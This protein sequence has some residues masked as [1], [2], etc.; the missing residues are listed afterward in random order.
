M[1]EPVYLS[2]R[3][4]PD[5]DALKLPPHSLEA[6]QSVLGGLLLDFYR[7]DQV[8]DLVAESDFYRRDHRL[9]F[10]AIRSLCEADSPADVVTVSEWLEK[11]DQLEAAGGLAYIG[12]LAKNT[13]SAANIDA[14]GRIVRE[15]AVLRGLIEVANGIAQSAY[16]P[17][18]RR[19]DE[20]LDAAEK[21]IFDLARHGTQTQK[22]FRS[23]KA[24]LPGVM[25][26]IDL[27]SQSDNPITGVP[28]G[29]KDL[30]ELTSGF[31]K[32]DLIIIAG[33]PSMGKTALAMNIAENAAL[34]HQLPVAIFSMEMPESQLAMRM[35]ASTGRINA[36]KFRTGK[37]SDD[38]WP[39]LSSAAHLLGSAPIYIDDTPALT[40]LEIRARSRRL[41]REHEH[42]LGLIVVDYLQLMQSGGNNENRATE[43]SAITR[44]LKALAKELDVPLV[45][46]SQLNRALEQR[47]GKKKIPVMSDLRES[48]SIEQ[49][50]DVIIFIYRDEVYN[51]DTD[52]KGI[53]EIIVGKQ[54]NGP[55][56][57]VRLTFLGEYTR[58]ENYT[59]PD[60]DNYY[61]H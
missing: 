61:S 51:D 7:W 29:Y 14:Y 23:M 32:A 55:I 41:A 52:E 42:G 30:D 44:S 4:D 56:G 13:P 15:R 40:P 35:L 1:E 50:A 31:Q 60:F 39:R 6:E 8:S 38:D 34:G 45:A 11:N 9:I 48:G 5:T 46:L 16:S 37:L 19:P 49:D 12:S 54:R 10:A 22:G 20:I 43:V 33:R 58:F 28:T 25:D 17:Q 27:L 36:Q 47:P 53:A 2:Q 26:R 18:G 24:A 57:T 21:E 59:S 3:N